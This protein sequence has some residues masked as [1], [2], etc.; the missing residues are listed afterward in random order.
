[1]APA[2][3]VVLVAVVALLVWRQGWLRPTPEVVAPAAPELL[4]P[5]V[6]GLVDR[7]V[8][9][10]LEHPRDSEV[11]GKLGMI[12]EANS[13]WPE[14]REAYALAASLDRKSRAWGFHQAVST[15]EAGDFDTALELYRQLA[16]AHPSF[17]PVRQRLGLA[18]LE[19]GDAEAALAHLERVRE[20]APHEAAGFV[21]AGMALRMLGRPQE[22]TERLERAL[23]LDPSSRSAHYQLGLAY[24]DLGRVEEAELRLA[25]GLDARVQYLGDELGG[26]IESYAI[27]LP[28]TVARAERLRQAGRH[29]EVAALFERALATHPDNLTLLNNLATSQMTQGDFGR[30]RETLDRALE[31]GGEDPETLLNLAGL[32]LA[33]DFPE[34]AVRYADRALAL[35]SRLARLHGVKAQALVKLRRYPEAT[36][37][38]EEALRLE[39][40]DPALYM[41]LGVLY[42]L[43]SRWEDAIATYDRALA[44]W[45]ELTP[46][47]VGRGLAAVEL[48]DRATAEESLAAVRR[49]APDHPRLDE[50]RRSTE[51]L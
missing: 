50:L 31:V 6:R 45:P 16:A 9:D 4:D 23:E 22:A 15:Q 24:R 37:S 47:H 25:Q 18:L 7:A 14:A 41:G 43:N 42:E 10:A 12:Y 36:L 2:A 17:A 49:L 1:L 33:T 44:L 48:G 28:A 26:E 38:M 20:L 13:L 27:N 46:V 35:D 51:S 3:G 11:H 21:G 39:V 29:G 32:A 8:A 19:T 30:A 40:R 34:D 5:A